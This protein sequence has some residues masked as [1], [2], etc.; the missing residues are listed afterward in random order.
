LG[1][2]GGVAGEGYGYDAEAVVRLCQLG[3][4]GLHAEVGSVFAEEEGV[5]GA[6][7]AFEGEGAV[8]GIGLL[9]EDLE[10]LGLRSYFW[11][12]VEEG[13]FDGRERD[14]EGGSF[15]VGSCEGGEEVEVGGGV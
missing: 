3:V 15:G 6:S 13:D 4:G 9:V 10:L 7:E 14:V 2:I 11:L 12:L 1:L 5:G 8:V